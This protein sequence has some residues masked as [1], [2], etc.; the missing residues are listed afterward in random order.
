M[1]SQIIKLMALMLVLAGSLASCKE[2]EISEPFITVGQGYLSGAGSEGIPKQGIVIETQEKWEDLKMAM[3]LINTVTNSF[4]DP[5][6][7][8]DR[9]LLIAVFDEVHYSG[10]WDINVI[11]ITEYSDR[12]IINVAVKNHNRETSPQ[13]ITQP[14]QI[15][16]IS[17]K[18][19]KVE[20]LYT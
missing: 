17:K 18:N 4:K 11:C 7:D 2:Q 10:D 19:K 14:Y 15:V 6:I 16:K 3:D 5:E 13:L 1:K 9:Y 8:F 20:F 12:I